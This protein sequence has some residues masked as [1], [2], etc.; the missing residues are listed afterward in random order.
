M[1]EVSLEINIRRK[2]IILTS[3]RLKIAYIHVLRK[4][5]KSRRVDSRVGIIVFNLS[6]HYGEINKLSRC[7]Y[8][9]TLVVCYQVHGKSCGNSLFPRQSQHQISGISKMRHLRVFSLYIVL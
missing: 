3:T 9:V 1:A 8:I 7:K 4:K 5:K 2:E 6:A